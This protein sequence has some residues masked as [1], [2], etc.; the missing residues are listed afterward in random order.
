[1]NDLRRYR[2]AYSL[3]VLVAIVRIASTYTIFS[4]TADE[5]MHLTAGLEILSEH[6]YSL[7]LVNPPL[8]RVVIAFAPWMAGARYDAGD[9]SMHQVL[10]KFYSLG[11]YK[12]MLV[13]ARVGTLLFFLI[14]TIA[15]A[16]WARRELGEPAALLTAVFFTTQP[17][18]LGHS[19]LATVDIAGIAGLAVALLAFS[20]WLARPTMRG[21]I[22][23]GVAYGL[24]ILCK[25]LC[26]AYVPLACAAIY[27][28][29]FATDD[30]ARSEWRRS[31]ALIVVPL[32]ALVIV[33]AGYGFSFGAVPAPAF[34]Q[35]IRDMMAVNR[36]GFASYALGRS[37]DEGWWWY[38]PLTLALKTTLGFL[39]LLVAGSF[40]GGFR[41]V[42]PYLTAAAAILL[43]SMPT[44]VDIG[45]RY[46][47]AI[48]VPLSVAA[49]GLT[50]T[51]LR[52]RRRLVRGIAIALLSWHLVSSF[53]IHPDYLAYFNEI[54]GRDPSR[55]LIDSNLDWGQDVLR[56]RDAVR[57]RGIR[58]VGVS[59]LGPAQLD[60]LGFPPHYGPSPWIPGRGWI[61]VSDHSYRMALTQGGW[62]WLDHRPYQRIGK[63]IRLYYIP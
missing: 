56:L 2:I 11:H 44:H 33:W 34:W 24:A 8:P 51:M 60:L 36:E 50:L 61:A 32:V 5:G 31:G 25:L 1:M 13:L 18:I 12:R 45:I 43:F 35:G 17:A 20:Y 37:S 59:V 21:A 53:A 15:T 28:V 48:Y 29:R 22:L 62:R 58:R 4:D 57:K 42:L 23:L 55:C 16:W 47:I 41:Q 30:R 9:P 27:V 19:G 52:H 46:I 38:F 10:T 40:A 26:I 39:L 14:A 6:R 49:A 63:S 3:I 54:A 7:H